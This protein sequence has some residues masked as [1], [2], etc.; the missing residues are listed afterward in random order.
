MSGVW[1]YLK[2]SIFEE[3]AFRGYGFRRLIDSIGFGWAQ[4]VTAVL[5]AVYH[6]VNVGMPLIPA[7]LFT[8]LGSLLFGYAFRRSCGV[9]VPIGLHAAWNFW[10]EQAAVSSGR[11]QAGLWSLVLPEGSRL[12][13]GVRYGALLLV[14]AGTAVAIRYLWRRDCAMGRTNECS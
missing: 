8:G 13:F 3:L 12:S 11:G 14:T 7:L 4:A 2:S 10:Q 9:I 6:T 1:F 5:F